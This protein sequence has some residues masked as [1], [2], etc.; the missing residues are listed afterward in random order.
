MDNSEWVEFLTT[1]INHTRNHHNQYEPDCD[2]CINI[3]LY[4]DRGEH[5]DGW[6]RGSDSQQKV[7]L[8]MAIDKYEPGSIDVYFRPECS[9]W[10]IRLNT[11]IPEYNIPFTIGA[12]RQAIEFLAI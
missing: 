3:S 9:E 1:A 11:D 12:F 10:S 5:P 7:L 6:E 4:I 8:K 2:L